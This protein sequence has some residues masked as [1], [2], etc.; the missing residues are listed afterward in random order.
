MIDPQ[1]R[2]EHRYEEFNFQN[3]VGTFIFGEE[4]KGQTPHF[5]IYRE[6]KGH[7]KSPVHI[8]NKM[9]SKLSL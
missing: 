9:H 7:S 2:A 6:K 8:Q 1:L 4:E 5:S 3:M